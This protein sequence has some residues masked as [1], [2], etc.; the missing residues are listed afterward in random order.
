MSSPHEDLLDKYTIGQK[1]VDKIRN[2]LSENDPHSVISEFQEQL[3][4]QFPNFNI[5]ALYP[6]L[7]V[8]G[9]SRYEI[10]TGILAALQKRLIVYMHS[11]S[12][13]DEKSNIFLKKALK[14]REIKAIRGLI[15]AL[16][17]K[18][19]AL[20][21]EGLFRELLPDK[22][23]IEESPL[24]LKRGFF[25]RDSR[26]FASILVYQ[27]TGYV[28]DPILRVWSREMRGT[29]VNEY[30]D[31][32]VNQRNVQQIVNVIGDSTVL[33]K[34]VQPILREL[35]IQ[36]G[37]ASIC[38]FRFDLFMAMQ[39]ANKILICKTD[40]SFELIWHVNEGIRKGFNQ[41]RL[42]N[43]N[44]YCSKYK[45]TTD[46][47][48]MALIFKDPIV[49]N[50]L[51]AR[52]LSALR[53]IA[54]QERNPTEPKNDGT[55][56]WCSTL[57]NLGSESRDMLVTKTYAI[58]QVDPAIY[59]DFYFRLLSLMLDDKTR[60]A[61]RE[62]QRRQNSTG[63]FPD[64]QE[65][66]QNLTLN[67]KN[68][69]KFTERE[70]EMLKESDLARKVFAHYIMDSC[71][72]G[73]AIA[74]K[75][76]VPYMSA[77]LPRDLSNITH[78]EVYES[79]WQSLITLLIKNCRLKLL[80]FP[81]WGKVM[82]DILIPMCAWKQT[83][84]ELMLKLLV[85]LYTEDIAAY[86]DKKNI[87][88]KIKAVRSWTEK[89]F[90][91]GAKEPAHE[92]NLRQ[93]YFDLFLKSGRP[94]SEDQD[95]QNL[96]GSYSNYL[97]T[98]DALIQ[99]LTKEVTFA[100]RDTVKNR[101]T[102]SLLMF[103]HL[104]WCV[105]R[106]EKILHKQTIN[107]SLPSPQL[108]DISDTE[109]S[110]LPIN[111]TPTHL[112][113]VPFSPLTR[114]SI[115]CVHALATASNKVTAA[116][117]KISEGSGSNSS[118][119][120]TI[121]GLHEDVR[122]YRLKMDA[123][124][125]QI[126][127][128]STLTLLYWDTDAVAK[129][130]T[131]IDSQLFG[132]VDFRKDLITKDRKNSKAQACLDFH[133][134][135]TNSFTHQ[136][137]IYADNTRT[138]GN[139]LR[140]SHQARENIIAHGL[141]IAYILLN[142]HRNFNSFA[143]LVKALK[144]PEVRRIR[145][146]WTN[147]STRTNQRF[148]ELAGYVNPENDYQAYRELITQKLDLHRNAQNGMIAIP[149]MQTHYEE[150]KAIMQTYTTGNH[151]DYSEMFLSA[152]GARKLESIFALLEQCKSNPASQEDEEWD[153]RK[154]TSIVARMNN[155]ITIDGNQ[156]KI[157]PD[158]SSL[159]S[160]DLE[161]HHW[162]VSR[163]YLTKQQLLDESIEIE[164]L[165][166]GESLPLVVNDYEEE[167]ED[168]D[169]ASIGRD[170]LRSL[171][172]GDNIAPFNL[173][174][175]H[176]SPETLHDKFNKFSLESSSKSSSVSQESLFVTKLDENDF[177]DTSKKVALQPKEGIFTTSLIPMHQHSSTP[178]I[179]IKSSSVNPSNPSINHPS[180]QSLPTLAAPSLNP[181][182]PAFIPRSQSFS[183]PSPVQDMTDKNFSSPRNFDLSKLVEMTKTGKSDILPYDTKPAE[184]ENDNYSLANDPIPSRSEERNE[185][186]ENGFVY[187]PFVMDDLTTASEENPQEDVII[188]DPISVPERTAG[189]EETEESVFVY[190]A[191]QESDRKE[192][193]EALTPGINGAPSFKKE[194]LP[195]P[196]GAG[197]FIKSS[198]T[199]SKDG[200]PIVNYKI[201]AE[202]SKV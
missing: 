189:T 143:A 109:P 147:L 125:V 82:E 133:R 16:L 19:P 166:E 114:L 9:L 165:M 75:R 113:L 47:G 58:P 59:E 119:I 122:V 201:N 15:M 180:A 149:W 10:H 140:T 68:M 178:A 111:A 198:E 36:F 62:A 105:Q 91:I 35:Y 70:I 78:N 43:I 179:P 115:E 175:T 48:D 5:N 187:H 193:I 81:Q 11:D 27:L 33:F 160:G 153:I 56:T 190:Q 40:P 34:A 41:D 63:P 24:E 95:Q 49:S 32:R 77:S 185:G 1:G 7:E 44:N 196:G 186:E 129:Q 3:G 116:N 176:K 157:P 138:S 54:N 164:P 162:L 135:L 51:G 124:N 98:A 134:Y 194:D 102:N 104:N 136:F 84:H 167:E 6:V 61:A 103:Q 79:L 66:R 55:V 92:E 83:A 177:A 137:M 192:E 86:L 21:T 159:D 182:A 139:S 53:K 184:D 128:V 126:Q 88:E 132:K 71:L 183:N 191:I 174:M 107:G 169:H 76:A 89:T 168:D 28:S 97:K 85:E 117:N 200:Q 46:F 99:K 148:K 181:H 8:S 39:K 172:S 90:N 142:V 154:K 20:Q 202:T 146:L 80:V 30:L 195:V 118:N 150:V 12:W 23:F 65:D 123:V 18:Y 144:S 2:K 31:A 69:S 38:S 87:S 101:P 42:I 156:I 52:L 197:V 93:M 106:A 50:V 121:R 171:D 163:V 73:D 158:L 57:I 155:S 161:L 120:Q 29:N 151:G 130:L 64:R 25:E 127:N 131:Y 199:Q 96:K 170:D 4:L 173:S 141:K 37:W 74:L 112:P 108:S 145:R 60:F 110:I 13:N 67:E 72:K 45:G 152:P 100:T 94:F 188:V 14:L 26:M 17:Q 22:Q